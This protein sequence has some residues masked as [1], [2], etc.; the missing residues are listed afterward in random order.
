MPRPATPCT[1]RLR[2]SASRAS[3]TI[4]TTHRPAISSG[5]VAS[6]A[7]IRHIA[8]SERISSERRHGLPAVATPPGTGGMWVPRKLLAARRSRRTSRRQAA[9][10][11]SSSGRPIQATLS[12][13]PM[14]SA[15]TE[16]APRIAIGTLMHEV[17]RGMRRALEAAVEVERRDHG[18]PPAVTGAPAPTRPGAA[19][20]LDGERRLGH[21]VEAA[22]GLASRCAL[23]LDLVAARRN[24][25]AHRA[26][27][28]AQ[29]ELL[30]RA[31]RIGGDVAAL[32]PRLQREPAEARDV[33]VAA[34]RRHPR[35]SAIAA[36]AHAPARGAHGHRHVVGH[37]HA[38]A[39]RARPRHRVG[40][41]RAQAQ[42]PAVHRPLH[43]GIVAEGIAIG[44][45]HPQQRAL[46]PA[47]DHHVAVVDVQ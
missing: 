38:V 2:I 47:G 18:R 43:L 30:G 13:A 11:P 25:G 33:D 36:E 35:R 12:A 20:R 23:G 46:A 21:R 22:D 40:A 14:T 44:A 24:R 31:R 39:D 19:Q 1:P 28:R 29:R 8:R 16:S 27:V 26:L 45:L 10:A 32:G 17:G 15:S 4:A 34:A 9:A 42:L 6:S 41:A 7:T 3:G 5:L 37:H